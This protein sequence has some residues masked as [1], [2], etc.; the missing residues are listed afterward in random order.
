MPIIYDKR[1]QLGHRRKARHA[2]EVS[3]YV[4]GKLGH[5]Y[6][7]RVCKVQPK[8]MGRQREK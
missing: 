6:M 7:V 1:V 8:P 5:A 4:P 2:W 3:A